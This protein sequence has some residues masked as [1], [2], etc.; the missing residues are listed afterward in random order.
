M[1]SLLENGF[2]KC[3]LWCYLDS[4]GIKW[5][6]YKYNHDYIIV[7][8]TVIE[9]YLLGNHYGLMEM[10]VFYQYCLFDTIKFVCTQCSLSM[11]M[12]LLNTLPK[13]QQNDNRYNLMISSLERNDD[14]PEHISYLIEFFKPSIDKIVDFCN[15]S[16]TYSNIKIFQYLYSLVKNDKG[17]DNIINNL[18]KTQKI[19][20]LEYVIK[21]GYRL[22]MDDYETLFNHFVVEDNEDKLKQLISWNESGMV[23]INDFLSNKLLLTVALGK[24]KSIV[25]LLVTHFR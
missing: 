23:F 19:D 20:M 16:T 15:Q 10:L 11:L 12:C 1:Y 17:I 13:G 14:N 9:N 24:K 25:Q 2:I 3:L 18:I 4:I 21:D 8:R 22:K 6:F 7:S 5:E